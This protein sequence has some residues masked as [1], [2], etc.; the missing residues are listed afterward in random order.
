MLS[1]YWLL[2][3]EHRETS[4]ILQRLGMYMIHPKG[5]LLHTLLCIYCHHCLS[6]VLRW[7][8]KH[9]Q[10]DLIT[11]QYLSPI[12]S[13]IP[14]NTIPCPKM[15]ICIVCEL[16]GRLA[17]IRLYLFFRDHLNDYWPRW[18]RSL[19]GWRQNSMCV[20]H[21]CRSGYYRFVAWFSVGREHGQ[22]SQTWSKGCAN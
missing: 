20:F 12:Q 8:E 22:C 16:T 5:T 17:S 1:M 13:T 6:L 15:S 21:L 9:L 14:F 7:G 18:L 3:C 4:S 11:L 10:N 19:H 2:L